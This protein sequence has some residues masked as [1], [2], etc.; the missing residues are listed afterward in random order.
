MK[1]TILSVL[2]VVFAA[3]I[4]RGQNDS[5]VMLKYQ[6]GV[7]FEEGIYLSFDE[8]KKN[9]PKIQE[10]EVINDNTFGEIGRVILRFNC[11]DAAG[12]VKS[13]SVKE[14]FCYVRKG[15]VYIYQ[16]YFGYYYRTF[17]VG[18]LTH[19][20]AFSHTVTPKMYMSDQ[21]VAYIGSTENYQEFLKD[22]NTGKEIPFKYKNFSAFL[23]NN[24][25]ELYGQLQK[26]KQKRK[27][28][29]NFLLKYNERHPIYIPVEKTED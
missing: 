17:I 9:S 29:H 15:V 20:L 5:V 6:E 25:P 3:F 1:R 16:G 2:I 12:N 11:E 13:C 26:T 22:F 27:M 23:K 7:R 24:D 8:F 10:Y 14:C 21:P 18:A 4:C 19:Y 28:I